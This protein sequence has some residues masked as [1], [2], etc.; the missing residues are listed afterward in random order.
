MSDDWFSDVPADDPAPPP[1]TAVALS[2]VPDI[3]SDQDWFTSPTA[4]PTPEPASPTPRPRPRRH[5][6]HGGRN[7]SPAIVGLVALLGLGVAGVT[8]VLQ[9][10]PD[11]NDSVMAPLPTAPASATS[12]PVTP[13]C[14]KLGPGQPITASSSDPG[15]RTIA[16]FEQAYYIDRNAVAA[17]NLV[18]PDARVGSVEDIA[19]GITTVPPGTT[20][21]ELAQT[22]ERG[23]HAVDLYAR[24]PDGT[25]EHYQQTI[26]TIDAPN[27]PTGALIT[28]VV[29][30]NGK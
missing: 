27:S 26:T 6:V 18:T 30:R 13:W 23:I 8:L 11:D 29:E 24:R 15:W 2:V 4:E 22:V 9:A 10:L 3:T 17:R 19:A 14:A 7:V 12:T 20:H 21:C 28:G 16:A 25:L 5:G 1:E